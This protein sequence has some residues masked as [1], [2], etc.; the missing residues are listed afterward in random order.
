MRR[1]RNI[2]SGTIEGSIAG[3]QFAYVDFDQ[4]DDS[5]Y[6]D[7]VEKMN[8]AGSESQLQ[9]QYTRRL[10]KVTMGPGKCNKSLIS[11]ASTNMR[12]RKKNRNKSK[13]KNVSLQNQDEW[14]QFLMRSLKNQR[15]QCGTEWSKDLVNFIK[16]EQ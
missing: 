15:D 5:Q 8:H 7:E 2:R 6:F 4:A 11:H 9:N 16:K 13:F 14:L 10:S 1:K 12:N 3:N